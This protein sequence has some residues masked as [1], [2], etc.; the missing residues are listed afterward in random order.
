MINK[1]NLLGYVGQDPEIKSIGGTK[2]A[3]MTLATSKT[4]KDK[5]GEKKKDTQWHNL[6]AWGNTVD[7]IEKFIKK[8]SLVQVFGEINYRSY[9]DKN[10]IKRNVTDIRVNE[11]VLMPSG[12]NHNKAPLPPVPDDI[13]QEKDDLPF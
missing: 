6:V 4:F 8:G 2:V 12:E 3:Q 9:E 11:L 10:G 1:V 13:T 7:I 5:N